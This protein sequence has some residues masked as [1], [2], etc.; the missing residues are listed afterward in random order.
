MGVSGAAWHKVVRL[1]VDALERGEAVPDEAVALAARPPTKSW[2]YM[3]AGNLMWRRQAKK[4]KV[5]PRLGAR[6]YA[7]REQS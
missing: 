5:R 1:T 6:P 4:N 7:G 2:L 3:L